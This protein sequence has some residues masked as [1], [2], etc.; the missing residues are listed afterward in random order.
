MTKKKKIILS[1]IIVGV[2][3]LGVILTVCLV[4]IKHFS[5]KFNDEFDY[6]RHSNM[7]VVDM[8][9]K[10]SPTGNYYNNGVQKIKDNT[11]DNKYGLFSYYDNKVIA[12]AKYNN[13]NVLDE[14]INSNKTYFNLVDNSDL[15]KINIVDEHGAFLS[16]LQYDETN[17]VMT[18]EIKSKTI[19]LKGKNNKVKT[20]IT[21]KYH[22]EKVNIKSVAFVETFFEKDKYFYETWKITTTDD[23]TYTNL[24][25]I[26]GNNHTLVQTLNNELGVS[27]ESQDLDLQF[28]V[29]GTPIF[30]DARTINFNGTAQSFLYEIYDI[31]FNL[32]GR[33]EIPAKIVSSMSGEPF[34][35]GNY[36][37]VQCLFPATANKYDFY[38]LNNAGEVSYYTL[39]TYKLSLKNGSFNEV[40]FDYVISAC[41]ADFNNETVLV[42]AMKIADKTLDS[43]INLLVNERLQVK[44]LDYD[45]DK[46]TKI[47]NDRY[48]TSTTQDGKTGN[49]NLIDKNYKLI[50]SLENF[51][52]IFATNDTIIASNDETMAYV[53]NLDGMV[54]KKVN[55][56]NIINIYDDQYYLIKNTK[57]SGD[58]TTDTYYLEQLGL[59]QNEPLATMQKQGT[60]ITYT[61]KNQAVDN[62]VLINEENVTIM[63]TTTAKETDGYTYN[64]YTIDGTHLGSIDGDVLS[65]TY[66]VLHADRNFV[67]LSLNGKIIVMDR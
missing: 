25:K 19:D 47:N 23:L 26:E 52:N 14:N 36:N 61:F 33:S 18:A 43:P 50:T 12:E 42:S 39:K 1:S 2:I 65:P 29:D 10:Y 7:L 30:L 28:L 37:I 16:F 22:N 15:K 40:K 57:E 34:R 48:I 38:T 56:S 54:I 8:D 64:I 66:N 46:I 20:K 44:K 63:V 45:F 67:L 32:L 13:I 51:D 49:Y 27:L 35:V 11:L 31:N 58:T 9:S 60:N 62:L 17:K 55:K 24:Y 3:L 21:N 6:N 53:C 5:L 59:T 4:N 41:N